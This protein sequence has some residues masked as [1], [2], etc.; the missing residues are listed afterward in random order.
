MRRLDAALVSGW[1]PDSRLAVRP[2]LARWLVWISRQQGGVKPPHSK[3][4]RAFSWFQGA[5]GGMSD[6]LENTQGEIPRGVYPEHPER[7]PSAPLEGHSPLP[8]KPGPPGVHDQ[9]R[10]QGT[11]FY[12]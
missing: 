3:A 5:A 12:W 8:R 9:E 7:D 6:C 2:W 4:L 1:M 10:S 11:Q